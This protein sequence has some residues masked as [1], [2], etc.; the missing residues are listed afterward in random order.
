MAGRR[1]IRDDVIKNLAVSLRRNQLSADEFERELASL[2]REERA[3][4][5]EYLDR[6]GRG[7]I[8]VQRESSSNHCR[9]VA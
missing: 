5:V 1:Q 4:L 8:E 9:S 6:L 3:S 2:T 7:P